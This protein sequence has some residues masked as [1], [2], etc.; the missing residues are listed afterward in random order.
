MAPGSSSRNAESERHTQ[1]RPTDSQHASA[2]GFRVPYVVLLSL[3]D[4]ETNAMPNPSVPPAGSGRK[5]S[6]KVRTGCKTCKIRKVKCDELKPFCLRCSKTG[7]KCDG[8]LDAPVR[9]G[10][11]QQP[12]TSPSL[13]YDWASQDEKRSL[14]FF[15]Q[16]TA[17]TLSGDFDAYFWRVLV[18]QI[19]QKE[20]AVRHAVLAVSSL[21]EDMLQERSSSVADGSLRQSFALQQYNKAIACMLGLMTEAEVKPLSPLLTCL[22]FVC[23]EFMQSKDVDSLN[24]LEKGRQILS[25]LKRKPTGSTK[26]EME[27]I[28]RHLV[29]MYMRLSFTTFM[30]GGNPAPIPLELKMVSDLPG[31]FESLDE[32]QYCLYD[33]MDECMRF[34]RRARHYKDDYDV[35]ISISRALEH[36]QDYL[37]RKL[38]RFNVAYS[39]YQ[40]LN[41]QSASS[42]AMILLQIHLHLT[43]IWLSTALTSRE[44]AFDSHLTTFSAMIPLASSFLNAAGPV[45]LAE[46][47]GSSSTDGSTPT[48]GHSS[49]FAFDMHVIPPLY[50]VITK[51]RHPLIRRAALDLLWKNASRREN[52]WRADIMAEMAMRH[53]R[54]EEGEVLQEG[55]R[56]SPLS[57]TDPS[58]QAHPPETGRQQRPETHQRRSWFDPA[59][60][61]LP[62]LSR[63][64]KQGQIYPSRPTQQELPSHHLDDQSVLLEAAEDTSPH[65]FSS[66]ESQDDHYPYPTS[67]HPNSTALHLNPPPPYPSPHSSPPTDKRTSTY[68][69]ATTH[70]FQSPP[71]HR[72]PPSSVPSHSPP[73]LPTNPPFDIPEHLRVQNTIIEDTGEGSWVIMFRRLKG[74]DGE[75]DARA[76]FVVV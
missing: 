11:G 17:P 73:N 49:V 7:R 51:C 12:Q 71:S 29:P 19:C 34:T 20:P 3:T 55:S 74:P 50:F 38:A 60:Q 64:W 41:P 2:F 37:I 52:L 21:H 30:L 68:Y 62:E 9:R 70:P 46:R 10:M 66:S 6:K 14:Q 69:T 76:E 67:S 42:T 18:L 57:S 31:M 23:I 47:K 65:S 27:M 48:G 13:T 36:E 40:A 53:V 39:L 43:S 24:H 59:T 72:R 22:L 61:P 45:Y 26:T 25:Q 56:L 54:L 5:G 63:P 16:V 75:W 4:S 44:T 1:R 15:Q 32:A 58:C 33:F 8:Y 35:P 28:T